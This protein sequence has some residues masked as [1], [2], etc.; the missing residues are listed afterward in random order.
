WII[1]NILGSWGR[2]AVEFYLD[3]S[4]PINSVVVAYGIALVFWH[5]RLRPYRRAAIR[6]A[7]RIIGRADVQR[8]ASAHPS[9]FQSALKANLDWNAIVLE[10]GEGS[11]VAGRWGLWPRRA[12]SASM[13]RLIP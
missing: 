13:P 11:L 9:S 10:V 7:A 4:L 5:V 1:D 3:Y 2:P 8:K 6:E 12:S